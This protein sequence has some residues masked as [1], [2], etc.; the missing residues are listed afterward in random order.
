L[1]KVVKFKDMLYAVDFAAT[2]TVADADTDA[3]A[4]N[5]GQ[6]E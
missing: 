3:T 4:P 2:E 1:K 5:E 6:S